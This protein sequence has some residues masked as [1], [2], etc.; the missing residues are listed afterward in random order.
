MSAPV[1]EPI[2]P[3]VA[4]M[5]P[6]AT[7]FNDVINLK[8]SIWY[9]LVNEI[10]ILIKTHLGPDAFN[11]AKEN[12][13]LNTRDDSIIIRK[14]EPLI[15]F[16]GGSAYTSYDDAINKVIKRKKSIDLPLI[17]NNAPRTHDWDVS[18]SLKK[19]I[20]E[21][22]NSKVMNDL[23]RLIEAKIREHFDRLNADRYFET[24]FSKI[25]KKK[26]VD[27][28]PYTDEEEL[29]S[30]KKMYKEIP[31]SVINDYI[32]LSYIETS[33][34]VNYRISLEKNIG[35]EIHKN[36]IVELNLWKKL[37][38]QNV[39]RTV[40]FVIDGIPHYLPYPYDLFKSNIIS[41]INRSTNKKKYPKCRQDF[42]R[43]NFIITKISYFNGLQPFQQILTPLLDNLIKYLKT[44]EPAISQCIKML[45]AD[46]KRKI[47]ARIESS[48]FKKINTLLK[49]MYND[50]VIK[51]ELIIDLTDDPLLGP[52]IASVQAGPI[53]P[54]PIA[55]ALR[56]ASSD[57]DLRKYLK[58]K[59]KYLELKKS[60]NE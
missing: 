39:T 45:T 8:R 31:I 40:E 5:E 53:K 36:H 58:Y 4:F 46:E 54:N 44:I 13:L 27:T 17:K 35:S 52:I 59:T 16:L 28:E 1:I 25:I 3:G 42:M 48:N 41:I 11:K 56:V 15:Y 23:P 47:E 24:N 21:A 32:E 55:P 49:I 19:D 29:D 34:F 43:L 50:I 7:V 38:M 10:I 37:P 60:L 22:T 9:L 30:E 26:P 18:F 33:R 12:Y 51:P 20:D 14:E 57:D 6:K 2:T